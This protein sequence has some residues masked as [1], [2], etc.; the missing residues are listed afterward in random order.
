LAER[1]G[2]EIT[3]VIESGVRQPVITSSGEHERLDLE[4]ERLV[5]YTV[6]HVLDVVGKSTAVGQIEDTPPGGP[7]AHE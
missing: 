4:V 2:F 1:A 3:Y 7:N 6:R 5:D